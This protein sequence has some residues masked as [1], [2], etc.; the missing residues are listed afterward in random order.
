MEVQQQ[1]KAEIS[2]NN[3]VMTKVH[4]SRVVAL[5]P[6]EDSIHTADETDE[7][8]FSNSAGKHFSALA[9][10]YQESEREHVSILKT[11]SDDPFEFISL[12]KR[13]WKKLPVPEM[14]KRNKM[15]TMGRSLQSPSNQGITKSLGFGQI[16]FRYFDQ[17]LGDH[18]STSYGPPISL[19]WKYEDGESTS[20]EDYERDRKRRRKMKEMMLN[21]YTRR[22]TLMWHYGYSDDELNRATRQ[23]GKAAFQRSVTKYFLPIIKLEEMIQSARR[24]A[25]RILKRNDKTNCVKSIM[26][27]ERTST[28]SGT[29]ESRR[30]IIHGSD[31]D[32]I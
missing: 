12:K 4:P 18:P 22:N 20:V 23:C 30:H 29:N 28:T 13:S 25:R 27:M 8:D 7:S 5:E 11:S 19:D 6:L 15:E 9:E 16:H 1:L 26:I 14:D 10:I 32:C 2:S 3:A 21:Y 17:T 31:N 24:K